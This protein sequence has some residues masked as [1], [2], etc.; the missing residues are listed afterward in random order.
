M[1]ETSYVRHEVLRDLLVSEPSLLRPISW[2]VSGA[3]RRFLTEITQ[4]APKS[5]RRSPNRS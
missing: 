2:C 5:S 4:S 3:G 1:V